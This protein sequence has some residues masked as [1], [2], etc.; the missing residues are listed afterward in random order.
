[1]ALC[2]GVA[3]VSGYLCYGGWIV[4]QLRQNAR[5]VIFKYTEVREPIDRFM[6]DPLEGKRLRVG[7][8]MP[9][10]EAVQWLLPEEDPRHLNSLL[11]VDIWSDW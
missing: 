11:V 8:A 6:A 5:P 1:M 10:L 2:A 9:E 7:D 4:V 3:L